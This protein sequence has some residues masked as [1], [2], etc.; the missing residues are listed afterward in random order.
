LIIVI[1]GC[2]LY[3]AGFHLKYKCAKLL[4]RRY[5]NFHTT[6]MLQRFSWWVWCV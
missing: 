3:K 2:L 4:H 5:K 1:A 6:W